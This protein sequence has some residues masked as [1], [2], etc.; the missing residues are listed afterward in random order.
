MEL[1]V[2]SLGFILQA[3]DNIKLPEHP[4]STLRGAFGH[5][6]KT[7]ACNLKDEKCKEC[8]LNNNCAYSLLFNPFLVGKEKEKTSKRF[9][10]KPRP[11]VFEPVGNGGI[12]K[13]GEKIEFKLNLFG[14]TKKFLPYIIEAWKQ[15]G[16]ASCRERVY[17]KV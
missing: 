14:Y 7:V 9:N 2:M 10:N 16:R 17:T 12:V 4:G 13:V 6:L 1:E 5:G 11:F 8:N 15:I 3:Q